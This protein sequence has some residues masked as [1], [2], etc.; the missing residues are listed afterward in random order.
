MIQTVAEKNKRTLVKLVEVALFG[1]TIRWSYEMWTA[2]STMDG[3]VTTPTSLTVPNYH[4]GCYKVSAVSEGDRTG[5]DK[6]QENIKVD[7]I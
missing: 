4:T 5:L 1:S 6:G 2:I 7:V 3:L